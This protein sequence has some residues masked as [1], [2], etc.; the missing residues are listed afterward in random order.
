MIRLSSSTELQGTG[1]CSPIW[2]FVKVRVIVVTLAGIDL[3][4]AH[5]TAGWPTWVVSDPRSSV[6]D[7]TV[8]MKTTVS[9]LGGLSTER[10]GWDANRTLWAS[11]RIINS[12]VVGW[13]VVKHV[14]NFKIPALDHHPAC[15][16]CQHDAKEDM[17][18]I[19]SCSRTRKATLLDPVV[20]AHRLHSQPRHQAPT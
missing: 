12:N 11:V 5:V 7:V 13:E 15:A 9:S 10:L 19:V 16:R 18:N 8:T 4:V 2:V 17:G 20:R 14:N 6:S 3:A 1:V